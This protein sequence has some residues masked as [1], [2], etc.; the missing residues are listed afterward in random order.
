LENEIIFIFMTYYQKL[1]LILC[2]LLIR[3]NLNCKVNDIV[4]V[5]HLKKVA[6]SF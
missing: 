6:I 2:I 4:E 5:N 1:Y 3:K